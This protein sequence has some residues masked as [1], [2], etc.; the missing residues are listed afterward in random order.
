[1]SASGQTEKRERE[2]RHLAD[3]K[4]LMT[5][6]QTTRDRLL[7]ALR[8]DKHARRGMTDHDVIRTFNAAMAEKHGSQE[9]DDRV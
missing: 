6:E 1:M 2:L 9:G 7:D 8:A 4:G 3:R 5:V